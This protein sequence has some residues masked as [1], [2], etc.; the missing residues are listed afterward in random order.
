[1]VRKRMGKGYQDYILHLVKLDVAFH[2]LSSLLQ[3]SL[4]LTQTSSCPCP[5]WIT[6][7]GQEWAAGVRR[8]ATPHNIGEDW[9]RLANSPYMTYNF[10]C[11]F[12]GPEVGDWAIKQFQ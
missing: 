1:M 8:M 9:Q 10:H 7:E 2:F 4:T 12:F 11:N 6:R 3:I 5:C